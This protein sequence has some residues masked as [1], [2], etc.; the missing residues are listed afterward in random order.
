MSRVD[1]DHAIKAMITQN[2]HTGNPPSKAEGAL[3]SSFRQQCESYGNKA[4]S[5]MALSHKQE[6]AAL[7]RR[8]M[9]ERQDL[10]TNLL[11]YQALIPT[12]DV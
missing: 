6:F 2:Q 11:D 1:K 3:I 4:R 7:D 5:D 10:E 9:L 8:H 12:S